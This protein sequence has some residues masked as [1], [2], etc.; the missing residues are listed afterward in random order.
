M[1]VGSVLQATSALKGH[2]ITLPATL[3]TT[4]LKDLRSRLLVPQARTALHSAV[5]TQHALKDTTAPHLGPTFM[6]NV[7]TEP[8]AAKVP[9]PKLTVQ[10][11]SSA[12][13]LLLIGT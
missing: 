3:A 12:Q 9:T 7:A 4:A 8:T 6:P 10:V 2:H 11:A 1:I 13:V 5:T